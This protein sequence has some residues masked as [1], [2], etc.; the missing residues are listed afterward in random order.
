M[1]RPSTLTRPTSPTHSPTALC[2]P[3]GGAAGPERPP[4]PRTRV[5]TSSRGASGWGPPRG[6]TTA[7]D[8]SSSVMLIL[9]GGCWQW[10]LSSGMEL[11]AVHST[12]GCVV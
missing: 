1:R 7:M 4:G 11:P 3:G 8:G 12:A 10:K 9:L 2:A 5:P 6:R